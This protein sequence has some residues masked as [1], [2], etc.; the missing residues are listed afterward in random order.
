MSAVDDFVNSDRL[1]HFRRSVLRLF[2]NWTSLKLAFDLAGGGY[3]SLEVIRGFV[4]FA[5]AS[6]FK[7]MFN[8]FNV[9]IF[10]LQ[11]IS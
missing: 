7:I 2:N 3:S 4:Y 10:C 9:F 1:L 6:I 5:N 11:K 8:F